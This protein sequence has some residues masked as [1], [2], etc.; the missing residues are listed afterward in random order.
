MNKNNYNQ[1]IRKIIDNSKL[2]KYEIANEVGITVY[3]FSH[4]LQ[5]DLNEERKTRILK[6]IENLKNN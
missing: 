2:K 5:T 3:T 4:W 6:A 1:E